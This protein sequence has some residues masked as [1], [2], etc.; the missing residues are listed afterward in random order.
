MSNGT[1]VWIGSSS[2]EMTRLAVGHCVSREHRAVR[3][4]RDRHWPGAWWPRSRQLCAGCRDPSR[5]RNHGGQRATKG[6]RN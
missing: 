3:R 2:P 6:K 5:T 4:C 1:I